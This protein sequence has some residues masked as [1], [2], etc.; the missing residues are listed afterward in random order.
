MAS[1]YV[2]DSYFCMIKVFDVVEYFCGAA[3]IK[4]NAWGR[5]SYPIIKPERTKSIQMFCCSY[6][7]FF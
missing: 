7:T 4:K 5:I 6:K 2:N 3:Y 1:N